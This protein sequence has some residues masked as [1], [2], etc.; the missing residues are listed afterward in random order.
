MVAPVNAHAD[1]QIVRLRNGTHSVRSLAQDETMHPGL[2]PRAEATALY[3][4]QLDLLARLRRAKDEFVIWDVGLGAGANALTVL[5]STREA[6]GAVRIHSFDHTLDPIRFAFEKRAQLGYF[7]GYER[8]VERL[9]SNSEADF[10]NGPQPLHWQW[11]VVDFPAFLHGA[12]AAE[13]PKPHA[14]LFDPWSPAKN[15]A[16]WTG[17]LFDRLYA[18][19]DP[20]R[21]CALAT[22]SRSTMLRVS[23]LLAGFHVGVGNASG[24]KEETTIAANS[25]ELILHPLDRRWLDRARRSDCAEPLREPVYRR[26]PLASATFER[27]RTHPQFQ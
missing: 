10:E 14:I 2:G 18:L 22:Y 16:M 13:L 21:P 15:P 8:T 12:A 24:L 4:Q 1:Y 19:L 27:L 6:R 26:A 3:V 7:A 11:H 25:F 9:L 20:G 17:P 5:Q 23:L